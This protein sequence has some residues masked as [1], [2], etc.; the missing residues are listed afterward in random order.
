[1]KLNPDCVRDTLLYLEDNI[2][3]TNNPISMEHT[4]INIDEATNNIAAK[5]SHTKEETRYSIEKLLEVGYIQIKNPSYDAQ[6]Y[7]VSGN[8]Y[9]ISWNGHNFLNN[10][11]PQSVWDA[12]KRGASRLGLMSVHALSTISM[13]IIEAIVTDQ[14]VISK[15]IEHIK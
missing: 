12:T 13:K 2:A 10:I 14:T 9:D 4:E 11:R 8:I 15:I 6:R 7:L 3:Y 5:Y 1:M